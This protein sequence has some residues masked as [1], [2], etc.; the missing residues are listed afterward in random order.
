MTVAGRNLNSF[1][2]GVGALGVVMNARYFI[3]AAASVASA[4][5]F[6]AGGPALAQDDDA[7]AERL[8]ASAKERALTI[9]RVNPPEIGAPAREI[10]DGD[11]NWTEMRTELAIS[12][13]RDI[14]AQQTRTAVVSRPAGMRAVSAD[15]FKV[16]RAVEVNR[17]QVPVLAPE[18]DRIAATLKVYAQGD[19]YSATA[20]VA[21]G[22]AMRMSGAKRKLVLGDAGAA[23][24]K[25]AAMRQERKTLASVGAPYLITRSDSATDLSFAKFGAGYVLS[26]MCDDADTDARCSGDEFIVGLASNLMLLNPEAGGE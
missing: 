9:P 15:R 25:L 6:L 24:S 23:R 21:D 22:V 16:V 26:I 14:G 17:A 4:V 7:A 18:G 12:A 5:V 1:G 2:A 19:S 11:I 10:V 3:H 8:R 13:R 20:E